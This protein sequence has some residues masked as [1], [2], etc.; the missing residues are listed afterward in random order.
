MLISLNSLNELVGGTRETESDRGSA[1]EMTPLFQHGD[2]VV[3]RNKRDE[4]GTI[5]EPRCP[6]ADGT[7]TE[8]FSRAALH[9]FR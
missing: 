4:R 1:N 2:I 3:R 6:L 5:R 9:R 7:T 8:C